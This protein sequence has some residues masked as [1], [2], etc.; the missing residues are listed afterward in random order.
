MFFTTGF[1]VVQAILALATIVT[2][3]AIFHER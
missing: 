1:L 2:V 3:I